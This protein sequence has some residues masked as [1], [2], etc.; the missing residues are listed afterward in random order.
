MHF[1]FLE[2]V[3]N[4]TTFVFDSILPACLFVC[5]F[6]TNKAALLAHKGGMCDWICDAGDMNKLRI[7]QSSK[8][9]N[10]W[11]FANSWDFCN[12]ELCGTGLFVESWDVT[13]AQ[14]CDHPHGDSEITHSL[15]KIA[16]WCMKNLHNMSILRRQ[17]SHRLFASCEE[18]N[19]AHT[20]C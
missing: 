1:G 17:C 5:K 14:S 13:R 8:R 20:F 15:T 10:S 7:K 16:W 18:C 12:P 19:A 4:K 3:W 11:C 2:F 6:S 9:E